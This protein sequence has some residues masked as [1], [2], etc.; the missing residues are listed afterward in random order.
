MPQSQTAANPRHQEE[1]K[2]G[3]K[4]ETPEKTHPRR[5]WLISLWPERGSSPRPWDPLLHNFRSCRFFFFF[6]FFTFSSVKS[7]TFNMSKP[8]TSPT[9]WNKNVN[10]KHRY[11]IFHYFWLWGM[12]AYQLKAHIYAYIRHAYLSVCWIRKIIWLIVNT[13]DKISVKSWH[14]THFIKV[15]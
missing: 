9:L 1:E 15:L 12:T 11:K 8:S 7:R 6:F 2:A 14:T 4:R 10:V 5:I 13:W 3:R